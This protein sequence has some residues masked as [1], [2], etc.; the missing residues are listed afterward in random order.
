MSLRYATLGL[1]SKWEASGYDIK[2]EFHDIMSIFW[3]THLSQIY[4]ELK[5]LENE[6]LISSKLI[7]QMGKPD[8]KIYSITEDGREVLLKWLLESNEI[9]KI[10]DSFLMQTFFLDNIPVDEVLLKLNMQKKERRQRL[11][12][13]K[14]M[15]KEKLESIKERNVMT[16]RIL[17]ASAVLRRGIE[18]E[19]QYIKWCEET[20]SLVEYCKYLWEK[21][22][23]YLT[24]ST[25]NVESQNTTSIPFTEVE[26]VLLKY[27]ADI[28]DEV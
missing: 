17:M 16:A 4:P 11:E 25:E 20:I 26:D 21:N 28:V 14:I 22:D 15:S 27:F 5:K 3:H 6:N 12:I 7:P 18:Q 13:M 9:P 24:P 10:K 19:K 2:K 23:D 8:K 1:L